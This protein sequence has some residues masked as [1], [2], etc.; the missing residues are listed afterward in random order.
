MRQHIVQVATAGGGLVPELLAIGGNQAGGFEGA[1]PMMGFGAGAL[2][3]ALGGDALGDDLAPCLGPAAGGFAPAEADSPPDAGS[4]DSA[5]GEIG[6]GTEIAIAEG[7]DAL[8]AASEGESPGGGDAARAFL[9]DGGSAAP[10]G[11]GTA[12]VK[13]SGGCHAGGSRPCGLALGVA[14]AALALGRARRRPAIS[15]NDLLAPLATPES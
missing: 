1:T 11:R 5:L 9:V 10:A 14:L 6:T 8:P 12:A 13:D 15:S 2:A 7:A 3:L 4:A